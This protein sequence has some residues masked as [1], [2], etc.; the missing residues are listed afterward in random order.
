[1]SPTAPRQPPPAPVADRPAALR[2]ADAVVL[3]ALALFTFLALAFSSRVEGWARIAGANAGAALLYLAAIAAGPRLR[4]WARIVLR[5]AAV[6]LACA[7]LFEVV[8]G[9][10]LVFHPAWLD[11]RVVDLEQWLLGVQPTLWL[12]AF[13]RPWLTEWLMFAYVAYV[14]LYPIVAFMIRARRGEEA[15]EEYLLALVLVNA[16]CDVGFIA[17][18]VAGPMAYMGG[19]YTVPLRGW[20]FTWLGELIRTRAH[21]VGGNLPSPHCAAATVMLAMAWRHHRA[22]FWALLPVVLSVYAA[23][24]YGRYHYATDAVVG[25]A[26]AGLALVAAAGLRRA[27]GRLAE[28]RAV[29]LGDAG[30][31]PPDG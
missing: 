22:A 13:T 10:Q 9:L 2:P 7:H 18:P 8:A 3:S 23:T 6:T 25:V 1:M 21:F 24:V 27:W 16:I 30:G 4:G 28:G 15:M 29:P 14:P 26:A 19:A 17:F 31:E 20:V 12:Q 5:V 11:A